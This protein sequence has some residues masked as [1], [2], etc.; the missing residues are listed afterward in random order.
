MESYSSALLLAVLVG[1]VAGHGSMTQ[2]VPRNGRDH[3]PFMDLSNS[4][5]TLPDDTHHS[6]PD[7]QNSPCYDHMKWFCAA[8]HT[9]PANCKSFPAPPSIPE[10]MYSS[11]PHFPIDPA[12]VKQRRPWRSAGSTVPA[13]PCG[14]REGS[15][16]DGL[17]LQKTLPRDIWYLG[18]KQPVAHSIGA[19]HGGG[20]SWRLCPDADLTNTT[21]P[22]DA[23]NCFQRYPLPFADNKSTVQWRNGSKK[24]IDAMTTSIGTFPA[25]SQWR[26]NP[27]PSTEFC[28]ATYCNCSWLDG[29]DKFWKDSDCPA[30]QPPCDGCWGG[31]VD[32]TGGK[33]NSGHEDFSVFDTVLVPEDWQEGDYVLQWRWDTESLPHSQVWTNCAD[34][35]VKKKG[36]D[37]RVSA[38]TVSVLVPALGLIP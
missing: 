16:Q 30:F 8:D 2:P 17:D 28:A 38:C 1:G 3:Q 9:G 21:S 4:G 19:N 10:S 36:S 13:S 7:H 11:S 14:M 23:E 29:T 25:G 33:S 18:D 27:I 5:C 37:A 12:D 22:E 20:Y 35:S 31:V 15:T 6:V 26:R 24:E 32:A 34:I